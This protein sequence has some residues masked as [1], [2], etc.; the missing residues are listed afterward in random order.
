[1]ILICFIIDLKNLQTKTN[2]IIIIY[3]II[4]HL[5]NFKGIA[6]SQLSF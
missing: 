2:G 1:M 4:I 3:G 6:N 5:I